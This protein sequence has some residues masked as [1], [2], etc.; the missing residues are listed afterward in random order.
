MNNKKQQTKQTTK[1]KPNK[2]HII[3][4]NKQNKHKTQPFFF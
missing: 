2:Q 1:Q 4:H 3:E